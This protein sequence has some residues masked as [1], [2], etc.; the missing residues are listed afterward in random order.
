MKGE[1]KLFGGITGE[2]VSINCEVVPDIHIASTL[3]SD[4]VR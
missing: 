2:A 4:Q 3:S 1:V